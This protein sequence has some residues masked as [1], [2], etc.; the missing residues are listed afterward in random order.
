MAHHLPVPTSSKVSLST[1]LAR[2]TPVDNEGVIIAVILHK[3]SQATLGAG[4]TP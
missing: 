1:S 4:T 3:G 2:A